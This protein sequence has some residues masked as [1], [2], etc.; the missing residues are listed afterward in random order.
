MVTVLPVVGTAA[1]L[2]SNVPLAA[3]AGGTNWTKATCV[4]SG[5]STTELFTVPLSPPRD[6]GL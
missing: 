5:E 4:P 2:A 3:V 6:P 1:I